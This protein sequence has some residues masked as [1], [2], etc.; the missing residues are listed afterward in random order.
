MSLILM[1]F[2]GRF[3]IDSPAVRLSYIGKPSS[4]SL[5]Y[6]LSTRLGPSYIISLRPHSGPPFISFL[7]NSL[8]LITKPA[9]SMVRLYQI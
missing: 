6:P 5:F 1:A 9:L 7:R 4:L 3:I 8:F 2:Y